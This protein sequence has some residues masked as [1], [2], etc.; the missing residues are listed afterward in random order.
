MYRT[1]IVFMLFFISGLVWAA[2]PV[3]PETSPEA[4][5]LLDYV[6]SI[7]GENTLTGQHNYIHAPTLYSDSA[8][9]ITG[10][11][12]AVWGGDFSYGRHSKKRRQELVDTAIAMHERGAVVT[13][14]WHAVRPT[15]DEPVGFRDSIQGEFF[16][17]QW[18]SV[19]T[20]GTRL[21][22]RWQHQVDAIVPYL[23]QLQDAKVPV[24]WRPYHEMN[25]IWFWWGNRPGENG[26]EK[27]WIQLYDRLVHH[28]QIHNLIWVWNPNAP[29]DREN[30]E[31]YAYELFFPGHKY[32]DIL[33]ADV[34]HNDYRQSH[35]DD[36]LELAAGK[37][38]AIGECGKLPRPEILY[39]QPQWAWFMCWSNWLWKENTPQAVRAL[40]DDPRSLNLEHIQNR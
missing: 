12:P 28:H 33:A 40:Y 30:D 17:A 34:Y 6:Y 5:Q 1:I 37:P 29:R 8:F 23:Q 3:N 4:R 36:L 31:A 16:D 32:V 20:P 11:Y 15:D 22:R 25:G 26:F 10:A 13:L 18:D 19:T 14:M 27:L 39:E 35:H 24:L 2:E 7:S 38:I 9:A 21:Y